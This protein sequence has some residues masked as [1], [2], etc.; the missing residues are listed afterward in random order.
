MDDYFY[1]NELIELERYMRLLDLLR[2]NTPVLTM[3]EFDAWLKKKI[4]EQS[5]TVMELNP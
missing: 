3:P 5:K 4:Q 2:E 1:A